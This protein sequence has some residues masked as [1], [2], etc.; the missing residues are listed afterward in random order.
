MLIYNDLQDCIVKFRE[1]DTLDSRLPLSEDV[2]VNIAGE[3][4]GRRLAQ[5]FQWGFC[6]YTFP[7]RMWECDCIVQR[8]MVIPFI[9][10]ETIGSGASSIVSRVGISP[11][12]QHFIKEKTEKVYVV[13]KK[14]IQGDTEDFKR[15]V[16]CLRLLNQ[17]KHPN[18]IPLWGS[19]T[20]CDEHH[21][22]FP[23]IGMD[24]GKFLLAQSR[25]Q[26]FQWDFTFY[27][28]LAGLASA[29][30]KTHRLLLDQ[31]HHEVDFEAIGYHHDLR[32]PNVLVGADTF[33]LADFGLGNLKR[34]DELSHTPH[35]SILGDYIAPECTNTQ[36]IPQTV[37][38]EIDVWA[39][40]CLIAEVVTYLLKGADAVEQFRRKRLTPGRLAR[41]IDAG[42]Y[43]PDGAVKTEVIDWME[44]L[45][46]E[47]PRP[48]LVPQL[49][50]ICLDA[51]QPNPQS[52]PKMETIHRRLATLSMQKHYQSVFEKFREVQGTELVST[53][54]SQQ[55]LE[56]LQFAQDRFEVWGCVMALSEDHASTI[57]F[58]LSDS[59]VATMKSLLHELGEGLQNRILGDS[60]CLLP[61]SQRILDKVNELWKSLPGDLSKSAEN[62]WEEVLHDRGLDQRHV[63]APAARPASPTN[64]LRSE[65]EKAAR[66]FK[67][68]LPSSVIPF[69]EISGITTISDVYDFT[70]KIQADQHGSGGLRN[71]Q[72]I[73]IYL[74]RLDGYVTVIK[75]IISGNS[76]VLALLWGPIIFLLQLSGTLDAAYD[77]VVDAIAKVGQY[78][79]NFQA[80][81]SILNRGDKIG[82]V[83]VLLFKD[84]LNF[85]REVMQP[86][87]NPSWMYD[88]D[89]SWPRYYDNILEVAHHIERLA[90]LMR[91]EIRLEHIQQEYKFRERAMDSFKAQKEEARKQEYDR[92]R[93][94]FNPHT[95]NKTLYHLS[96][97]RCQD[98]GSWLFQ[99]PTFLDW[100][101]DSKG[102]NRKTLWLKGIPG[103][104]KTVLSSAVVNHLAHVNRAKTAFAFLTYQD[105]TTSALSTIHSLIFQLVGRDANLMAIVCESV[106][107]GLESNL[108]KTGDL[109]A[110]LI[111]YVGLVY[112]VL[113]GVDEIGEVE[114]GRLVTELLRLSKMVENLR[115]IFSTRPEADLMRLLENTAAVINVHDHN[116]GNI[117]NYIDQRT[118]DIFHTRKVFQ[119]AQV[120]IKQ[121]LE[122]LVSRAKGMFLYARLVM[123]MIAT[124]YDPSE[125]EREL[126][127]LPESLDAAYHRIIVRLGE[128]KDKRRA[129][130]ARK[131]LGWIACTSVPITPEEAQQ[132][133]LV[134]PDDRDQVF[135]IVAGLNV[136]EIIGPIVE[137]V[138]T[139]IQF[140]HFTAKEKVAV[141]GIFD[142]MLTCL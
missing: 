105:A 67:D 36:E 92:I 78:L 50:D 51:L 17:L 133:L 61:L 100:V 97:L 131:L 127:V 111:R 119:E 120:A 84:I 52:R 27:S 13:Q 54:L 12:Q 77:S 55:H 45:R 48:N 71:L 26:D 56:N 30:S 87:T 107:D 4:V 35:K 33:I 122:P 58:K 34:I 11:S 64:A 134:R 99:S 70:D 14:L 81:D 76:E 112:V 130:Q 9:S 126:T 20:C 19:Y 21:F 28:A 57:S 90:E 139:Y 113:D 18:I 63:D 125:I 60:S 66:L 124:L 53:R 132:A 2:A 46:R 89:R 3:D 39:F 83:T 80:L 23:D 121:L 44:A 74:E 32:P 88:F 1:H 95:Y 93:T 94:S 42:F 115:I 104:G 15:E 7:E 86:F 101:N 102:G 135:N 91:T 129:E 128:H 41:W 118:Q 106:C 22:I 49:I 108:T 25:H 123:D 110:S 141:F 82:G 8:K 103:A 137:I 73:Q 68:S 43:Q 5:D 79:P 65:F 6:P 24:L 72:K 16:R 38:R 10:T 142:L 96:G 136:V 140:V 31:A 62:R 138:D 117:K 59:Y 109:L 116:E 29:L 37:D 47:Y 85:Y 114:R 75:N 98:T 69:S 40:G